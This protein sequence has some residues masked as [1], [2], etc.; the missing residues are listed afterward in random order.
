[1][2]GSFSILILTQGG[3]VLFY[4]K[5]VD[6]SIIIVKLDYTSSF[7]F[8]G[9]FGDSALYDATQNST[10]SHKLSDK[11]W[12]G[13]SGMKIANSH[14]IGQMGMLFFA[15]NFAPLVD[16]KNPTYALHVAGDAYAQKMIAFM[17]GESLPPTLASISQTIGGFPGLVFPESQLQSL[18]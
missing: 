6:T 14:F 11:A 4:K 8:Y 12:N 13:E 17:S 2:V 3:L 1:M 10:E 5:H 16:P 9:S 18:K 15:Q 7:V